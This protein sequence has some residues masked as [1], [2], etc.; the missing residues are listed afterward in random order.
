MDSITHT[1]F[2]LALYGAKKK[3]SESKSMKKSLFFTALVGSQIPDIDVLSQFTATGEVMYQMWHRGLTHSVFMVPVWALII[4]GCCA[5]IWKEKSIK[6]F[7]F[8]MLAVLIHDVSDLFNAWGTGFLEPFSAIR[9]TFG[10][11]PIVDLVFWILIGGGYLLKRWKK[12]QSP[13]TFKWVWALMALH[14]AIQSS[15]G[16]ILSAEAKQKYNQT[17]LSASFIP[18]HFTVVGKSGKQVEIVEAAVWKKPEVIATLESQEQT[19][20]RPL[21]QGNPKAKALF[22]WA[23]F[24]VVVDNEEALGIYDPRFYRNGESFLYEAIEKK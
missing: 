21:F 11:I 8:G 16:A 17:A 3:D 4:W 1:L 20:L 14:V 5:W 19:D 22:S 15:Q 10:T 24:V 18:W 2:G 12:W 9:I 13:L 23:P 6:L 7:L